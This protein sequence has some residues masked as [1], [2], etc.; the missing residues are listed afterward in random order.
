MGST[1]QA[2]HVHEQTRDGAGGHPLRVER[3]L[4]LG[5]DRGRDTTSA[6]EGAHEPSDLRVGEPARLGPSDRRGDRRVEAVAVDRDH[7]S[8][9]GRVQHLEDR[10]D[11]VLVDLPRGEEMVAGP[12][13]VLHV[14]RPPAPHRPQPDL[15]DR[16]GARE[17][18]DPPDRARVAAADP[19][20]L[21]AEID[22]RVDVQD[23]DRLTPVE[24]LDDH[25]RNRVQPADDQRDPPR[26]HQ[27]AEHADRAVPDRVRVGMVPDHVP[28]IGHGRGA[29]REQRPTPVEVEMRREGRPVLHV[30][31]QLP[32]R[33]GGA[34]AHGE[35][36]GPVRRAERDPEERVGGLH[37]RRV[38]NDLRAE[39]RDGRGLQ[40][41]HRPPPV[42]HGLSGGQAT[43]RREPTTRGGPAQPPSSALT[44]R[45]TDRML[46]PTERRGRSDGRPARGALGL[47]ADRAPRCTAA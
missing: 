23:V 20:D 37:C 30:A 24:R 14:P 33:V 38:G 36:L 40:E 8:A 39:E 10:P 11:T 31:R 2:D 22:V 21:V 27:R 32:D 17:L 4:E 7:P 46:A 13:G 44:T 5:H 6:G 25:R 3:G 18:A 29:A 43:L 42:S 26:L 1:L 35:V 15:H 47:R 28:E 19:V 16:A 41:R 9:G 34:G 12:A 45:L